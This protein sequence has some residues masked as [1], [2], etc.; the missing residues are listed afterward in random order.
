MSTTNIAPTFELAARMCL[1]VIQRTDNDRARRDA[2]DEITRYCRQ[3]D[4]LLTLLKE[5][6]MIN[7]QGELQS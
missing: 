3:Y 7:E 4:E 5:R 2:I 6:G 1:M